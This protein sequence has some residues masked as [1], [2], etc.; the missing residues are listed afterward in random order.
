M[1]FMSLQRFEGGW[2]AGVNLIHFNFYRQKPR[3]LVECIKN[4]VEKATNGC[5]WQGHEERELDNN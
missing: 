4:P 2:K 1:F 5:Q 3:R